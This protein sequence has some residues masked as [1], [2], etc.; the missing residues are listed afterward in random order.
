MHCRCNSYLHNWT[1]LIKSYWEC[2]CVNIAAVSPGER[3]SLSFVITSPLFTKLLG[4]S[5]FAQLHCIW[6]VFLCV[7]R[8]Q[9]WKCLP[10]PPSR[11]SFIPFSLM[12][13]STV[14]M[15]S[16]R[17]EMPCRSCNLWV[18]ALVPIPV[19]SVIW[20]ALLTVLP[21]VDYSSC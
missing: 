13:M 9:C 7:G 14:G 12:W 8:Q 18:V 6:F 2:S 1:W 3:I 21:S 17:A 4:T 5:A 19:N 20:G 15:L 11:S 16:T 10:V